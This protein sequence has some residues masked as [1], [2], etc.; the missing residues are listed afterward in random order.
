MEGDV[1][2]R[3]GY[4]SGMIGDITRLHAEYYGRE[5]GFGMG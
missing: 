2:V 4:V 1:V 5:W 3:Q